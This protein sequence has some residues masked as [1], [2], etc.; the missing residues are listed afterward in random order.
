[1]KFVEREFVFDLSIPDDANARQ[2]IFVDLMQIHSLVNR[3]SCRQGNLVGIQSIEIGC[4][5]GGSYAA[6]IWRLPHSWGVTN[7]WEKTMRNWLEQ[8]NDTMEEAD[9]QSTI[10]RYRDFKV[11]MTDVHR[12]L[13]FSANALPT[14]YAIT[15]GA[16]PNEAYEWLDSR[17]V[18]P[19]DAD[20]PGDTQERSLFMVGD[21]VGFG[22]SMVKAYAES[23]S[24]P[25][26][27]DPN[28]VDVDTGG[29]FGEMYDVGMDDSQ[30]VENTQEDNNEPPYL[31][32]NHDALEYYP[33]GAFQGSQ[34][35]PGIS[36]P[37]GAILG[38]GPEGLQLVDILAVN[39]NQNYNSDTCPGFLAPCGLLCL[40]LQGAGLGAS[41][42]PTSPPNSDVNAAFWMKITLAPGDYQGVLA[43]PMQDVN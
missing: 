39:A 31:I 15:D 37:A 41:T 8:Q 9:L 1:M 26:A 32:S 35:S 5:T 30:I 24:R 25:Q 13:S 29:L 43:V 12:G 10:A 33:G 22:R 36:G 3:I 34:A 38:S 19:N 2:V 40:Q 27:V 21:D 23:R 11:F 6:A 20:V 7:A 42:G 17:I 14:G 28:I 4:Q 18:I 16:S